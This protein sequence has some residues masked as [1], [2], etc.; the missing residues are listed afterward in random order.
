MAELGSTWE[1]ESIGG[2]RYR[3]VQHLRPV[4]Y[5]DAGRYQRIVDDWQQGDANWPHVVTRAPMLIYTAADGMRRI[6]PTRDPLRYIEIGAP[7]VKIG[8]VWQKVSL[9]APTRT[10]NR[11]AWTTTNANVYAVMGGHFIKVAILLKNGWTPPGGQFAFPVGMQGLTRMGLQFFQGGVPV[12]QLRP[13]HVED[14]DNP[15]DVRP[16]TTQL[17]QVGGQWYVLCTLPGLAGMSRPLVDPTLTLQPEAADGL[18]T[19]LYVASPTFNYGGSVQHAVSDNA[20]FQTEMLIRFDVSSIPVGATVTSAVLTL[21]ATVVE[22]NT[23]RNITVH[24]GL[25]Q[26][27]EGAQSNAEPAP[28]ED[29]STWNLRNANGSVA[30]V[31]GAGGSSGSDYTAAATATTAVTTVGTYTWAIT[32]DVAA[33]VAGTSNWGIWLKNAGPGLPYKSFGSS[34]NATAS[35]RPQLVIIYSLPG[36]GGTRR[37]MTGIGR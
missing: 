21:V 37:M 2:G 14:M 24:R 27:Y 19:R 29:A 36:G 34:D 18:D 4:A 17:V 33:W 9:G 6:C 1:R 10:G 28:G 25:T 35:Y 20:G 16:V 23:S 15:A 3:H 13:L 26:W 32:T 30:W 31:G 7:Y 5:L 12:M 11:L 22:N 8:G